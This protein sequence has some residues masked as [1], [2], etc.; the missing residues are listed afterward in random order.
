MGKSADLIV[1]DQHIFEIP[2]SEIGNTR[3]ITTIL[4]GKNVYDLPQ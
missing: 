2:A 3:V 1:L 4:E